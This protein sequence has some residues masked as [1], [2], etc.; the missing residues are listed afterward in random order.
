[1]NEGSSPL[2]LCHKLDLKSELRKFHNS[3]YVDRRKLATCCQLNLSSTK[4][5]AAHC[6]KLVNVVGLTCNT[7]D[8]RRVSTDYVASLS[9]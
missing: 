5:N 9:Q 3:K 1:M 8:G 7:C 2:E 4:V 6:D